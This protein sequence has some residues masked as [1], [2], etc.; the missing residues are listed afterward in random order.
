M[1]VATLQIPVEEK[2][3]KALKAFSRSK[4]MTLRGMVTIV[5]L[6]YLKAQ[7]VKA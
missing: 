3:L 1:S 4:G 7:G 5:L 6:D 2:L